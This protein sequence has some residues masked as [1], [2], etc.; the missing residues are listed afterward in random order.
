MPGLDPR[1]ERL[2]NTP[3]QGKYKWL[4][5]VRVADKVFG[6]PC[7]SPN[8]L[9]VCTTSGSVSTFGDLTEVVSPHNWNWHGGAESSD[10]MIYGIP[11]NADRVLMIDPRK[12]EATPIGPLLKGRNKW[13]G[14]ILGDNGA[15]YGIPYS[16]NTVL[17]IEPGGL[18]SLIDVENEQS[19]GG[20][21]WHGSYSGENLSIS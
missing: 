4:R 3:L 18:V 1:V 7:W 12:E 19:S 5:G 9:K 17:K 6:I 2:G 8:V 21:L 14:G 11:S 13:Y 10:G 15:I 16:A 20:W